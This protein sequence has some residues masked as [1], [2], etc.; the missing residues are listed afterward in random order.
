MCWKGY[1]GPLGREEE[2][3]H[4]KGKYKEF[5]LC[6]NPSQ[7]K[8]QLFFCVPMLPSLIRLGTKTTFT[9][10][11][12]VCSHLYPW[13]LKYAAFDIILAR[14]R[15]NLFSVYNEE[16]VK[17]SSGWWRV[18]NNIRVL[19]SVRKCSVFWLSLPSSGFALLANY[20]HKNSNY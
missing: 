10:K 7:M 1:T 5:A 2:I 18:L 11:I 6:R 4:L 9:N 20:T 8:Q 15:R 12:F 3:I 13:R 17:V 19:N 16:K 14:C